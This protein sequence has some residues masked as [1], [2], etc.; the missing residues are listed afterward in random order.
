MTRHPLGLAIMAALIPSSYAF[1]QE[2]SQENLEVIEV[3]GRAQQFYLDSNTRIGTKTD[4]DILDLPM[5][6][7][8][9]TKQLIIDQA[10]RDITD[11]YRSIAGVSEY[12]YS[13]VTFRGFRD[14]G[15]V[16]Y[17]GVRG[18]PFSGFSVPQLFNVDRIEV[19]KGPAAA[20]YGGGEPG[21]MIN[22]VMKKPTFKE[23]KELKLS[24]GSD[25]LVGTSIDVTGGLTDKLAY[26]L[27]G[28]F[29]QQDSFRNNADSENTQLVGGILYELSPDTSITATFDYIDQQ[30]GGNRLRGVPVDDNGNFLVDPSYN[31]NESSDYQNLKALTLQTNLQH[32]F[33]DVFEMNA[34]VRYMDNERDQAY[35]ESRSWI[36]SDEQIIK[37]EYRD[38]YRANEELSVTLDFV[39]DVQISGLEHQVL[40]GSDYHHVETEYDYLRARYEADGVQNL[41]IYTLNYGLTDPSTYNLTDL[42]RDGIKNTHL[43]VYLQ[44]TMSINQ[45]WS[46]MLGARIDKFDETNKESGNSYGD[47]GTSYR[48]GITYKPAADLSFYANYSQSFTPVDA[49]DFEDSIGQLDPTTGDQFEIGTKKEWL[50]GRILTTLAIY[51]IDK[52]N[53]VIAN[54]DYDEVDS[55]NAPVYYNYGLVESDG[56]ELTVVGDISDKMS[57]T[58]NYAYNDTRVTQGDTREE[59]TSGTFVNAPAHQAGVW[60]RY[61]ISQIDSSFA[62]GANY[63]SEQI[64]SNDQKVKSFTVF[65]AS[66]TT[67]WDNLLLSINVNNIFDKEYA[68]SGF[69]E[70]NGHFP[71]T[72]REVIAQVTYN[73]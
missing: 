53:L 29:D 58:A 54:P 5:S 44:D 2:L 17:D 51:Q 56:V 71:G 68:V 39:Y 11:M 73:F 48:A 40:F 25:G 52:E 8:V 26:R 7:Q 18:D 60:L 43:G 72:P 6:A 59:T 16:F 4:T 50:N 12:S 22:Y 64:S 46:L 47:S 36:D 70:R 27:G 32:N 63:V 19:L 33:S 35:H 61:D 20:L 1:S 66:W 3:T 65:D 31:A 49:D 57:I 15:N 69:S 34:T 24:L 10:A 23:S 37:R 55:P 62:A 42:N 28:F 30:L 67:R 21:G 9:L 14:D 45:Q 13:G 38:Q 41:N